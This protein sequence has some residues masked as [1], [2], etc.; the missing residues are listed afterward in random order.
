MD[1]VKARIISVV[2]D[3]LGEELS[4]QDDDVDLQ[5]DSLD[6][7]D[8]TFNLEHEFDID[9]TPDEVKTAANL[10]GLLALINRRL[11]TSNA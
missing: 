10:S 2:G 1:R 7:A 3:V 11:E 8:L 6:V 5:M 4:D 9:L